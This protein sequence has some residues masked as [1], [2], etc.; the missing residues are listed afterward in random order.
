MHTMRGFWFA[1]VSSGRYSDIVYGYITCRYR[2]RK[3]QCQ[4][5]LPEEY[6]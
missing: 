3:H 6:G 4:G 1:E 5:S 2:H